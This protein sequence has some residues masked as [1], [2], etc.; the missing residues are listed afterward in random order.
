VRC[1][2]CDGGLR[3]WEKT[4][5]PWQEHARWFPDCGFVLLI[6]GQQFIDESI[7]SKPPKVHNMK[8]L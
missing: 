4:D 6:K 7:I 1:F 2:H 8:V 5:I 3:L